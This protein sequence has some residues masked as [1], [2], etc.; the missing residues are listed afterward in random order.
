MY[1]CVLRVCNWRS[2]AALGDSQSMNRE[3]G[4][5]GN[6]LVDFGCTVL[7]VH[8]DTLREVFDRA[9]CMV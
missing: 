3:L 6:F 4:G 5:I 7:C 8:R 2:I 9:A 1:G